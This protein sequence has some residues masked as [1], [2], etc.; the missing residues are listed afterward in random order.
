MQE[1]L[2]K[3]TVVGNVI[4]LPEGQL[5]KKVYG[6]ISNAFK[7]IGGK[8]K[9]GNTQGFVF[10]Y[11]PS[12]L[13]AGLAAGLKT[14]LKQDFQFYPTPEVICGF[15]VHLADL[16][17]TDRILEPSAGRGA[18]INAIHAIMP[19]I[20]VSYCELMPYNRTFLE[21]IPNTTFLQEDFLK[22]A[23][24]Q[25]FDKIL[26]NPPF[27]KNQD[28]DHFYKMWDLLEDGGKIISVMSKHWC[29]GGKKKEN[30]FRAFLKSHESFTIEME[31]GT[32]KGAGTMVES[33]VVE[34][35][36][37]SADSKS[38]IILLPDVQSEYVPTLPSN[39]N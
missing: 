34:I 12:E 19:K 6:D 7:K 27:S 10:E 24:G 9:G 13:L 18:I 32:F 31:G 8:W 30:E 16:R 15:L 23:T 17:P 38:N 26:A 25:K 11:D 1:I 20:N 22:L 28:I 35:R 3:C 33:C 2:K 39:L 14:N 4:K 36:K 37:P 29:S 5:D 21:K